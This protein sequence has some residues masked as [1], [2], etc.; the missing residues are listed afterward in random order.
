MFSISNEEPSAIHIK[1]MG[2]GGA[3]CNA[4]NTMIDA[5]LN[6]VEFVVANTDLQALG[7]SM[8]S[9]KIQLG[10]ERARGLGAGA[11]PDV[12]KESALES[13][14]QIRDALEGS[15]MV[16]VTAGMGGGTGTGAAP[17]V[18][19]IAKELGILTV[20]VVTKPFQY[21]GNRRASFA[22]E[23]IRELK[24]HV[25]S[26]LIIP[27]QK[28][29]GLVDKN[30]PLLEAFKIVDDVLRQAIQGISDVI[31]T[32]GLVNVDFAD[33][34]TVMGY[35]GRAVMGMGSG[36]GPTRAGDAAKQAISSPLLE[37]GSVEGARGLL[38]NVTGGPNL[39]LHEVDEAS[40]IA[41]EAADPQANIIV[42][43]VINTDMG[44]ELTV[45][46][47][48]TG[49]EQGESVLRFPSA[50]QPTLVVEPIKAPAL[51]SVAVDNGGGKK[52]DDL[53][54]PTYLRQQEATRTVPGNGNLLVD[55]D[56]DV[57]TFLRKR[58]D[59]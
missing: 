47:I 1:V 13:E 49:F 56:W 37:D 28:L 41:R 43:Q 14:T 23:G 7:Q 6:R 31:T 36:H 33:V 3:G 8:A 35:P 50:N 30:T 11:R 2:V 55:D 57:P 27:N 12:G 5:G 53:D 51:V 24:K 58:A 19:K 29:L 38:L 17:I 45:T 22:E 32:P 34:R 39:T 40:N 52:A 20:G 46:V 42:G 48:A 26:V 9:Y 21:E 54:R 59:G 4:V 25:D 15:D 18:A 10:P 44:D 16:F